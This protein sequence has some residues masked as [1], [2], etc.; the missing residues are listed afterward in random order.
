MPGKISSF[1]IKEGTTLKKFLDDRKAPNGHKVSVGG[2]II[3]DIDID[4]VL[5]D[6]D[7]V[8]LTEKISGADGTE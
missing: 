7:S 4:L 1:Q 5:K 3:T 6:K 8:I 2:K